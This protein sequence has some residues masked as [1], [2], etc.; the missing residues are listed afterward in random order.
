MKKSHNIIDDKIAAPNFVPMP[1]S[2]ADW[3]ISKLLEVGFIWGYDLAPHY[4]LISDDIEIIVSPFPNVVIVDKHHR[5]FVTELYCHPSIPQD[6]T[7]FEL[8][9]SNIKHLI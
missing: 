7:S 8:F 1:Y 5:S 4:R 6:E 9:F 3:F 2:Y